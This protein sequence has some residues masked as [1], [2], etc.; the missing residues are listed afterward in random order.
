MS[1]ADFDPAAL[2]SSKTAINGHR[3]GMPTST[4]DGTGGIVFRDNLAGLNLTEV[5]E[6]LIECGNMRNATDAALLTSTTFQQ[7]AA[8]ALTQAIE[9]FLSRR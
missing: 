1:T 6:V 9:R 3:R 2:Y 7:Q 8:T 5:P 4:Y